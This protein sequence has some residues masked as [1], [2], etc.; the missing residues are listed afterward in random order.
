M[1]YLSRNGERD[2]ANMR[3]SQRRRT[4]LVSTSKTPGC[5]AK[6]SM[7]VET[8][9]TVSGE[10]FDAVRHHERVECS[11]SKPDEPAYVVLISSDR[12]SPLSSLVDATPSITEDLETASKPEEPALEVMAPPPQ[13]SASQPLMTCFVPTLIRCAER[14]ELEEVQRLLRRGEDPNST[15]DFG[16]TALHGASKKGHRK[17]VQLLLQSSANVNAAAARLRNETP[18]HYA[19]KYGRCEVVQLLLTAGADASA[20]T[21]DGRTPLQYA[22]HRSHADVERILSDALAIREGTR[23]RVFTEDMPWPAFLHGKDKV[24]SLSASD[25]FS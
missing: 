2:I 17:V 4:H 25:S 3:L 10:F 9:L 1:D 14:G 15:D 19:S 18:L 22:S 21:C 6:Q 8:C 7:V 23:N 13:E 20:L 5:Q 11:I 16:L 24:V 12:L